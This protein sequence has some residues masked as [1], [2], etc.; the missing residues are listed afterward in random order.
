MLP[1]CLNRQQLQAIT[2]KLLMSKRRERV[3]VLTITRSIRVRLT[4]R[5]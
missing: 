1:G 4:S 5:L 2:T 3:H